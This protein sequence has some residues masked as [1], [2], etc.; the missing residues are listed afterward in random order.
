M[1]APRLVIGLTLVNAVLLAFL[2]FRP[3]WTADTVAPVLRG[4]A[5]QIVDARGTVRASIAVL[6]AD[7]GVRMPDGSTG[8]PETVLLRLVNSKGGP[9]VKLATTEDGSVLVLG[10]ESNPTHVQVL[11]RGDRTS[12]KL[13]DKDGH[14]QLV[15]PQR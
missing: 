10:G 11:A 5:L 15:K 1:K 6:P 3:A 2:L 14:E 8:Y 9:N 7:P 13:T 4:R 12:L